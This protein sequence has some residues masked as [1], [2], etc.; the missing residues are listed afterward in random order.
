MKHK[1]HG[2]RFFPQGADETL[3]WVD[4]KSKNAADFAPRI[5]ALIKDESSKGVGLI[6]LDSKEID[7]GKTCVVQAGK[8]APL[9]AEVRWKR[10]I[11]EGVIQ[12][13]FLFLE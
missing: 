8:L 11:E 1:R 12:V 2:I 6:M 10:K 3:A 9:H 4:L 5:P 7:A 13:G